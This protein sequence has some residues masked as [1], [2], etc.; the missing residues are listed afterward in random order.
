MGEHNT[1][2]R[3]GK[4]QRDRSVYFA[5][6]SKSKLVGLCVKAKSQLTLDRHHNL[7]FN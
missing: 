2:V 5:G 3:N 1:S 4:K 7:C 6:T